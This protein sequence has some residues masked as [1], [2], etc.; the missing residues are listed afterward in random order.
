LG[1]GAA[2]DFMQALDWEAI[3][4]H[5]LRLTRRLLDVWQR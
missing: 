2:L 1:S 4:D 5:E 3:Q